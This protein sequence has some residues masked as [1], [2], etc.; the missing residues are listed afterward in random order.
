MEIVIERKVFHL[1]WTRIHHR[2]SMM[3]TEK[4]RKSTCHCYLIKECGLWVVENLSRAAEEDNM[5]HGG[6]EVQVAGHDVAWRR[7]HQ[8]SEGW[9]LTIA[10]VSFGR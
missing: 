9:L 7:D 6:M 5:L 10:M 1:G 4:S 3:V 8:A 2:S